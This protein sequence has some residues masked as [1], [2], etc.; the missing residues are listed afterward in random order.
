MKR[1]LP[2]RLDAVE[3]RV[4]GVSGTPP[5]DLLETL[6]VVQVR[7]D[8]V[9][10]FFRPATGQD[11]SGDGLE[12]YS[13]GGLTSS[14]WTRAFW[15]LLAPF[16][17]LN[18]AGW[19]LPPRPRGARHWAHRVAAGAVRLLALHVTVL[20]VLWTG[21]VAMEFIAFQCGGASA[22]RDAFGWVG[23]VFG[24]WVDLPGERLVVGAA[25]PVLL[26]SVLWQF[27]QVSRGRYESS[28]T[29]ELTVEG[30]TPD[31]FADPRL[32][33]RDDELAGLGRLHLAAAVAVTALQVAAS[34]GWVHAQ[35]T[36]T[37]PG[38]FR[39]LWWIALGVVGAI[40]VTVSTTTVA[41]DARGSSPGEQRSRVWLS[42]ERWGD[43]LVAASVAVLVVTGVAAWVRPGTD[44]AGLAS[45]GV[46][47][48]GYAAA[49]TWSALL[50]L[51]VG[52]VLV[53]ALAFHPGRTAT[54]PSPLGGGSIDVGF[55][56]FGSAVAGL[57]G[58]ATAGV[59][60]LGMASW[61]ARLLGGRP[62]IDYPEAYDVSALITVWGLALLAGGV[63]LW[64]WRRARRALGRL[65]GEARRA[66]HP[67][68]VSGRLPAEPCEEDVPNVPGRAQWLRQLE[69]AWVLRMVISRLDLA[70]MLVVVPLAL[71]LAPVAI[72]PILDVDVE[73]LLPDAGFAWMV[74]LA[75][76]V[77]S[78]GLPVGLF[79][80]LR[81]SFSSSIAR[82]R[83]GVLWDVLTFWP[84]W[85]HPLAPPSYS[86]R[87]VPELQTRLSVLVREG[88]AVTV[89]AHSQGSVLALVAIDGLRHAEPTKAGEVVDRI[90]LLTHGSPI[91]RLYLRFF[92]ALLDGSIRRVAKALC[93]DAVAGCRWVN[94]YRA[95][96]P[97]GGAI[98]GE[99]GV[100]DPRSLFAGAPDCPVG[101]EIVNPI[102]D[103][104][105]RAAL[106]E[107][108]P[109][110]AL[111]DPYPRPLGH[112]RYHD[113]DAY[114]CAMEA[115]DDALRATGRA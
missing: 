19:M 75:V 14:S 57:L 93:P 1:A 68:D 105:L 114:R 49:A 13:W 50:A 88:T 110:P 74:T 48:G 4:H 78:V 39:V 16:A 45:G 102:P 87:A 84:R 111:G 91:T 95:S 40:A 106:Q 115:L 36:G 97:I 23:T 26:V 62:R 25:V 70:V 42:R 11:G 82:R 100:V 109:F 27:G 8:E 44:P 28:W 9:A 71:A 38:A 47:L 52:T 51:L 17:L 46:P 20:V 2:E 103:P 31:S 41:V 85:Y 63:G 24:S 92:P 32:W 72:S 22:C 33:C 77:V 12:A 94:L 108:A 10:G 112:S 89:S 73:A 7:G 69:R 18:V 99:A 98:A 29:G 5:Q 15:V 54:I 3:L 80:L 113:A 59:M 37:T 21:Q 66:L 60:L 34:T 81:R 107:G 58:Y 65:D 79:V 43:G 55:R 96:D 83:V 101:G 64:S 76:W 104:D 90:A 6:D 35:A 86:A 67:V 30:A 61:V 56:G 53:L